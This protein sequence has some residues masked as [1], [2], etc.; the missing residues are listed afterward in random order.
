MSSDGAPFMPA[1]VALHNKR[2]ARRGLRP[3]QSSNTVSFG[4]MCGDKRRGQLVGAA[5]AAIDDADFARAQI[6]QRHDRGARRTAGAQEDSDFS[7]SARPRRDFR[8]RM[9]PDRCA[10]VLRPSIRAVVVKDQQ[11]DRARRARRQIAVMAEREG[12]FL[13]RHRDADAL[14][15]GLHQAADDGREILRAAPASGTS[16]PSMPMLASQ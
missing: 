2:R 3:V 13:V 11:I 12:R 15:A 7:A 16:A 5:A 8:A 14:E 4:A 1:L 10:S 9:R 6:V